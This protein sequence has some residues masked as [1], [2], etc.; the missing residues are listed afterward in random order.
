MES[1]KSRSKENNAY[2]FEENWS[3]E[4]NNNDVNEELKYNERY[5]SYE[6][7]NKEDSEQLLSEIDF[8]SKK[9]EDSLKIEEPNIS[10]PKWKE[11]LEIF[12]SK[13]KTYRKRKIKE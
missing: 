13:R 5:N 7:N 9:I 10:L 11:N 2:N 1:I 12:L 3:S 4:K 6:T 8:I